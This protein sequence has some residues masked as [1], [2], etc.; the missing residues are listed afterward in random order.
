VRRRALAFLPRVWPEYP[1]TLHP[2]ETLG[3]FRPEWRIFG[4]EVRQD[5]EEVFREQS[6]IIAGHDCGANIGMQHP[7]DF[8][9]RSGLD[10]PHA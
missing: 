10:L 9:G 8:A 7:F 1:R 4:F 5:V 3:E 6:R 2:T